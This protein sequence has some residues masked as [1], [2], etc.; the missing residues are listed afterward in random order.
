[1]KKHLLYLLLFFIIASSLTL[2][3]NP[4]LNDDAALYALAAKNA[5]VHNQWLAQFVTP[6]DLSSFLDKPPLGIWMLALLPKLIGINELTI[7]IPN[8]LYYA[9]LLFILYKFMGYFTNK[10]TTLYATLIAATSLVLIVYSRA[11]KLDVPLTLFI[12]LIHFLIYAYI[13]RPKSRYIYL[14]SLFMALGFLVKSGFA[15]I[16]PGLTVLGL[17]IFNAQIRKLFVKFVFSRHLIGCLLIFTAITGG[18]LTLQSLALKEQWVPYLKSIT[19]Q[20]KYNTSYLGVIFNYSII[21]LLMITIFPWS[22][23][24][25]SS[26]KLKLKTKVLNLH[27]FCHYW[28]W[29]NFLFF[30]FFFRQTD[31]RTFTVLVP[32]LAIIAAY[33]LAAIGFYKKTRKAVAAWNVFFIGAFT[34]ILFA[35][36]QPA[37]NLP[38]SLFIL[39]LILF[40][41][42]TIK[43]S[44][45]KLT[46]TFALIC[47]AYTSLFYNTLP[48][49]R[50]FN[51]DSHW[52]GIIKNYQAKGYKF[53]IYR[54]R[55]RQ[56]I[57]SPDLFYVDFLAGPADQYIWQPEEMKNL[58][59]CIALSD[60]QSL[61]KLEYANYKLLARD[62]YSS[63]ILR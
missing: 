40:T 58:Q 29:S 21:G 2:I 42:Y 44:P 6:G 63:L 39:A 25:F 60:S 36:K 53:I 18:I 19:I 24:F 13:K 9:L 7:H 34:L 27:T 15:I 38:L 20:S 4:L 61:K 14:I 41:I 48:L 43:P 33:K 56:L 26:I 47:I 46:A 55:D 62:S 54:P 10:K 12:T 32:P 30:L 3:R 8:L 37:A 57:M 50:A 28:F 52:P 51:D 16:L 22:S 45:K 31:L 11:P 49:A 35:L 1:M 59:N 17:I 5:I 23:L